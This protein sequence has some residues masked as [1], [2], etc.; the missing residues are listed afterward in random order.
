MLLFSISRTTVVDSLRFGREIDA[1]P[2]LNGDL[3]LLGC[4]CGLSGIA[5]ADF[6]LWF[7]YLDEDFTASVRCFVYAVFVE[8]LFSE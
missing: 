1:S 2:R 6:T 4:L 3:R 8:V 7:F 5:Y